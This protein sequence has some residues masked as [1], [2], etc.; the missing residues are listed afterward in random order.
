MVSAADARRQTMTGDTRVY[1]CRPSY[2]PWSST[3]RGSGRI[4]QSRG[5]SGP[6]PWAAIQIRSR[7]SLQ[8]PYGDQIAFG[9]RANVGRE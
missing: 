3:F 2:V 7:S 5:A 6:S 9:D 8:L 4:R 1:R